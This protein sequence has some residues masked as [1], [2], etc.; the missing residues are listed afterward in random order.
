[1]NFIGRIGAKL[2]YLGFRM[3]PPR[4]RRGISLMTAIGLEWTKGNEEL[5]ERCMNGERLEIQ[6]GFKTTGVTSAICERK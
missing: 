3:Q 5:F 6:I 2:Y 1:M 4:V